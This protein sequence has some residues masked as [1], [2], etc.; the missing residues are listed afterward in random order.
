MKNFEAN[1]ERLMHHA[2]VWLS[3]FVNVLNGAATAAAVVL[4]IYGFAD[5]PF[6]E[7]Y[8][9]VIEFLASMVI[10]GVAACMTYIQGKRKGQR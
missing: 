3:G 6:V 4:A 2:K 5:V 8:G 1:G 7:G 10:M 9:A